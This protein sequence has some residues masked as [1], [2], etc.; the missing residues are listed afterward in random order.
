MEMCK[1]EKEER[2]NGTFWE[3]HEYLGAAGYFEAEEEKKK[4]IWAKM[5]QLWNIPV[6]KEKES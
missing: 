3:L 6:K 2:T 5:A 1:T 4:E